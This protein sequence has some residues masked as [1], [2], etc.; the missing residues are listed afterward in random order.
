MQR[1]TLVVLPVMASDLL[2]LVWH[3]YGSK[4]R[5]NFPVF[6]KVNNLQPLKIPLKVFKK[7]LDKWHRRRSHQLI[8][9]CWWS[10]RS[11]LSPMGPSGRRTSPWRRSEH[12]EMR[13]AHFF[14]QLKVC[15]NGGHRPPHDHFMHCA[16]Y[17]CFADEAVWK[18]R[19]HISFT[20]GPTTNPSAA[21][22][23]TFL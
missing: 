20:N 18:R 3:Q 23:C 14:L 19:V 9:M 21:T 4:A 10:V 7:Q 11:M 13:E 16:C 1:N 12:Y 8:G 17:W 15:W 5:L 2:R 6:P 22:C